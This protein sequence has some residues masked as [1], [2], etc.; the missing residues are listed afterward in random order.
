MSRRFFP[1]AWTTLV[2][3]ALALTGCGGPGDTQAGA[4]NTSKSMTLGWTPGAGGAQIPVAQKS[5]WG[6]EG[7]DVKVSKF[8]SG[9]EALESLLG[10][11]IDAAVLAELPVVTAALNGSDV[12]VVDTLSAF[13]SFKVIGNKSQGVTDNISS[14][15]GKKVATTLG[16][17]MQF[18]TDSLLSKNGIKAELTNV[19][20]AD[21]V[22][23]LARGDVAAA[24]MFETNYDVAK[25]TL[26]AD[27]VDMPVSAD[28]YTGHQI[29]AV[30]KKK[31]DEDPGAVQ[32]L[33]SGLVKASDK[34]KSD[35]ETAQSELITAT[36]GTLT[37]DYLKQVWD[38]YDYT[39]GVS[40]EL[41]SL[42]TREGKWIQA[43]GKIG[44]G[45]TVNEEFFKPYLNDT[46]VTNAKK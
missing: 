33:V 18:L 32:G 4:G 7:L 29:L 34:V 1:L 46:F 23:A 9:R 39:P 27:Y 8:N 11:G 42:M 15:A 14:I 6:A 45:L 43:Q 19:G 26:G 3:A 24:V 22:S 28:I 13:G 44:P 31:V 20:A 21:I 35:P 37:K 17:N 5:T 2:A 16:T 38:K 41:K 40:A 10:G 36:S 25:Q 30:S 12:V